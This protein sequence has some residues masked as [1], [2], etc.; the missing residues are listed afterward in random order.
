MVKGGKQ[1]GNASIKPTIVKKV[2][3][4]SV[5]AAPPKKPPYLLPPKQCMISENG[6]LLIFVLSQKYI[7]ELNDKEQ[8][9]E[10]GQLD[11]GVYTWVIILNQDGGGYQI[12]LKRSYNVQEFASKHKDIETCI[13]KCK[14]KFAGELKVSEGGGGGEANLLSGSFTGKTMKSMMKDKDTGI[15]EAF[16]GEASR[17]VKDMLKQSFGLDISVDTSGTGDTFITRGLSNRDL[18]RFIY[19]SITRPKDIKIYGFDDIV[20][21]NGAK[22]G[23]IKGENTNDVSRL[24]VENVTS[25]IPTYN[26]AAA[27]AEAAAEAAASG[28]APS[29]SAPSG[30]APSGSAPPIS[31]MSGPDMSGPAMLGSGAAEMSGSGSGYTGI[32]GGALITRR[33]RLRGRTRKIKRKRTT[34]KKKIK[35]NKRSNKRK[36][37]P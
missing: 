2:E 26:H 4:V 13:G 14:V 18:H 24:T 29:G 30:S 12:Y 7:K 32:R 37:R 22:A 1:S 27:A 36:K 16:Q 34:T 15:L 35:R 10:N 21:C 28:S 33:H 5:T 9:I 23:I 11:P 8:P 31:A 19:D 3:K 25:R 17:V 6:L 20:K